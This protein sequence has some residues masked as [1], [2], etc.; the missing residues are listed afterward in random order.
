M[1]K[2]SLGLSLWATCLLLGVLFLAGCGQK[3]GF[4]PLANGQNMSTGP[5]NA[6]KPMPSEAM[7]NFFTE[8]GKPNVQLTYA[9]HNLT[10]CQLAKDPSQNRLFFSVGFQDVA[11]GSSV[12]VKVFTNHS[13]IGGQAVTET[14]TI[15][16]DGENSGAVAVT[17]AGRTAPFINRDFSPNVGRPVQ[18]A[19]T[20]TYT[21]ADAMVKGKLFCYDLMNDKGESTTGKVNF[22][23]AV[24]QVAPAQQPPPPAAVPPRVDTAPTVTPP[25]SPTTEG[26]MPALVPDGRI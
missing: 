13:D 22:S 20:I 8:V 25:A 4:E 7:I 6:A 21:L 17:L 12:N 3:Q 14:Q 5:A 10:Q 23:C 24:A 15:Y 2:L 19:C 26:G 9:G 18:S 1:L 16:G 11:S